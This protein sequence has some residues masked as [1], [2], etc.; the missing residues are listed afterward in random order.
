M[1]AND[2]RTSSLKRTNDRGAGIAANMAFLHTA[3]SASE[4]FG[5]TVTAAGVHSAEEIKRTLIEFAKEPDGGLIVAPAPP[6]FG[7]RQMIA[8]MAA[9]L[10]LPAVY[11]YRFFVT[12]G[13]WPHIVLMEETCGAGLHLTSTA[14]CAGKS[15]ASCR[16]SCR[17]NTIS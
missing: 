13:G 17:P 3:E 16:C 10:H 2:P 15:L 11:S 14:S 12:S 7:N 8:D 5:V 6:T 9:Q 4:A 1:T